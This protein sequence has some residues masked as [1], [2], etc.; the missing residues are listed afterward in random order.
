[1]SQINEIRSQELESIRSEI[2]KGRRDHVLMTLDERGGAQELVRQQYSGRYPFELLQN[3]NDAAAESGIPAPVEFVLTEY[4]LIVGDGGVGFGPD[5][6]EAICR[7]G[8]SSKKPANS[9]G[10]KGLGFKSVGEITSRPQ[11]IS[12]GLM[13]EFNEDRVQESLREL[14]GNLACDQRLPLYAFP[15]EISEQHLGRD[16][17]LVAQLKTRHSTIVRLPF[18]ESV[19]KSQVETHLAGSLNPRLLLLLASVESLE[20]RGTSSDFKACVIRVPTAHYEEVLLQVNSATTKAASDWTVAEPEHWRIYRESIDV[21]PKLVRSMG[22]AWSEVKTAHLAVAVPFTAD[23]LPSDSGMFPLHVYFPTEEASGLPALLHADFALELDRRRLA[24]APEAAEYNRVLLDRLASLLADVVAPSLSSDFPEGAEAVATIIPRIAA[25]TGQGALFLDHY[26]PKLKVSPFLP[27]VGA[28]LTTPA[29]VSLLPG[30]L[31]DARLAHRFMDCGSSSS[32]VLPE[33]DMD[34]RLHSFLVKDLGAYELGLD[35]SLAMLRKPSD[36]DMEEFYEFLVVWSDDHGHKDFAH[37]L[38]DH[39]C[40]VTL[41]GRWAKPASGIYFPRMRDEADFPVNFP[42]TIARI[43]EVDGLRILMAA[44]G[45]RPFEWRELVL[46]YLLPVLTKADADTSVRTAAMDALRNYFRNQRTGDQNIE[47]RIGSVLVSAATVHGESTGLR[48]AKTVYFGQKWPGSSAVET[49]YGPFKK[50]EF[51]AE[52]PPVE[53]EEVADEVRFFTWLGVSHHPKVL[54]VETTQR[55]VYMTDNVWQHPHRTVPSWGSWWTSR[56]V[57]EGRHC[58]Q[59]HPQSQQFQSSFILDRF[60]ELV[61]ISGERQLRIIWAELARNWDRYESSAHSTFYCQ[62]NGHRGERSRRV[63][64]LMFHQLLKTKWVPASREQ[65]VELAEPGETWRPANDTPK[66][67]T[68]MVPTLPPHL[69]DGDGTVL[70]SR[71]GCIDS[72][73]P[74]ASNLI[75]LLQKIASRYPQQSVPKN[76]QMVARWAM[77]ALNDVLQYSEIPDTASDLPLLSRYNGQIVFVSNPLFSTDAMNIEIWQK[78]FPI[79]DGDRDFKQLPDAMELRRLEDPDTG[80]QVVP[81]ELGNHVQDQGRLTREIRAAMPYLAAVVIG[82]MPSREEE[83]VRKLG[84]L[85]VIIYDHLSL[86]HSFDGITELTQKSDSFISVRRESGGGAARRNIATAHIRASRETGEP[87]W[88]I[89]GPQLANYLNVGS[90]GDAFTTLLSGNH[91]I[92]Q[93]VLAAKGLASIDLS[94]LS[95]QLDTASVQ[96]SLDEAL[97]LPT[98]KPS[99]TP[100]E[101]GFR[102]NTIIAFVQETSSPSPETSS[103]S[104]PTAVAITTRDATADLVMPPATRDSVTG[105]QGPLGTVHRAYDLLPERR[106]QEIGRR[107]EKIAL[108]SEISRVAQ[109]SDPENVIWQSDFEPFS[110]FDI[111]SISED[112]QKM[113]IEVKATTG[114]NPSEPFPISRRELEVARAHGSNFYIY[115]VTMV[116][117]ENPVVSRFKDPA[118]LIASGRATLQMSQAEMTLGAVIELG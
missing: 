99:P 104:V 39:E 67:M 115:R 30:S 28:G 108:E 75:E 102:E 81:V 29:I 11:I 76:D 13:F 88:F 45:V 87:D 3:A 97:Y 91:Q 58:G 37:R 80:V 47:G 21:D 78:H 63:P 10:Y 38:K 112:G 95:I 22:A 19:S 31:R 43:P 20:L 1:M 94:H 106:R 34:S 35:E 53:D 98:P 64:S 109:F 40:V 72:A 32:L 49:L 74:T 15:F 16:A 66:W 23:G 77:R 52:T 4:S 25:A 2:S 57:S 60:D 69:L 7:L 84:R 65:H 18:N 36:Q 117:S 6:V 33:V 55:G 86:Q 9:I 85:E 105:T 12:N 17:E 68:R 113:Y 93:R 59:N 41:D 14:A 89:F 92:R 46:N 42:V 73:R 79:L 103:R 90:L 24:N 44:T 70:S 56:E 50:V 111:V 101:V 54:S 51:L 27:T 100:P 116:D 61:K 26:L 107:G 5:E 110:P 71:L 114:N 83:A 96:E 48:S 8:R 62:A 82:Q 118:D